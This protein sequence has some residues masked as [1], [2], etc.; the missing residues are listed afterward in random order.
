MQADNLNGINPLT[1]ILICIFLVG[2]FYSWK[3][4]IR[5]EKAK[6]RLK[7]LMPEMRIA[8]HNYQLLTNYDNYFSNFQEQQFFQAN[9]ATFNAIPN[10]YNKIGL[11]KADSAAISKFLKI[12]PATGPLTTN[13]L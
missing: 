11:G 1:V 7:V 6:E 9:S 8:V 3:R 2:L 4:W 5:N 10:Y 12:Q 13:F